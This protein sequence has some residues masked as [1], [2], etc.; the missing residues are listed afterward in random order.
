MLA[1]GVRCGKPVTP[2]R[3]YRPRRGGRQG[4]GRKGGSVVRDSRRRTGLGYFLV[5]FEDGG[6]D[7]TLHGGLG[8]G[9]RFTGR[10]VESDW[11][12][13]SAAA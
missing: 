11:G 10:F 1:R 8:G 6:R 7:G 12:D 2:L 4:R 13:A 5:R 3:Q 9:C